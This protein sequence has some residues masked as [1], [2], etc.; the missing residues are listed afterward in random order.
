M[1]R[2]APAS[3]WYYCAGVYRRFR[4]EEI[5]FY[6]AGISFN[7]ILCVIPFFILL[8]SFLGMLLSSSASASRVLRDYLDTALPREIYAQK[9]RSAIEVALD[10]IVRHR[11]SYGAVGFL[12]LT[13]RATS[14]FS[15]IR[16]VLN[17][18]YRIRSTKLV[19]L[20]VIE[21]VVLVM[22]VGALFF[23]ANVVLW[24]STV[25]A[26]LAHRVPLLDAIPLG[27]FRGVDSLLAAYLPAFVMFFLLN[28]YV[29][30]RKIGSKE[31]LIAASATT[32]LWWIVTEGFDWY[33][34]YFQSYSALYGAYAFILVFFFWVYF[35][36]IMFTVGTM[37]AQLYR[38][39][40]LPQAP[41]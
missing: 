15:S 7:A 14:L 10:D 24:A 1:M 11:S 19:V 20:K 2:Q 17:T 26:S 9:L 21:E 6:A 38:E 31:A 40:S 41:R 32:V 37:I 36:A 30:D 12:I 28:R 25:A 39:R 29:P 22:V 3:A 27:L 8:T 16:A 4:D 35:S 34:G 23:A 13:W 5:F 33:L 18:I